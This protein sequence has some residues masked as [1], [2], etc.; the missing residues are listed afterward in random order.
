[1]LWPSDVVNAYAGP[2]PRSPS[3]QPLAKAGRF[4][5]ADAP[6][7]RFGARRAEGE[8]PHAGGLRRGQLERVVFVV[9]PAAQI[10]RVALTA[11]LGHPHD[12]DEEVQALFGLGRQQFDVGEVREI[13]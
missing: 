12:V 9:V 8:M 11:A 10:D 3:V 2:W 13:E 6:L 1:M 5:D 7:Q 4:D